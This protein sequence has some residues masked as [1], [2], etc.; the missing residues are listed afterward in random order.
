MIFTKTPLKDAYVVAVEKRGDDRGF[1][2]RSF[3]LDEFDKAGIPF[4]VKQGNVSLSA[5][6]GTLRGLHFQKTPHQEDKLI[7]CTK[8]AI[9]DV[10]LDLRPE[11]PTYKQWFGV[12]LSEDNHRAMLCPKGFAHGQISLTDNAEITYLVSEFYSP[13]SE[14]GIRWNDPM[15]KIEWPSEPTEMSDKDK[16]WPDYKS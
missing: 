15:F 8:G 7:R 14:S 4:V 16:N 2:G 13:E 10:I 1:F 3:C 11:S 12:E 6:K 5:K 9:F